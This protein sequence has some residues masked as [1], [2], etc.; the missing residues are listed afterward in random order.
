MKLS[1]FILLSDS[2]KKLV[3]LHEG[4]LIAKRK[5]VSSMIFLFQLGSY[6]VETLCN[7]A[8]KSIEE[9]RAFHGTRPLV[10][11]LEDIAIDDLLN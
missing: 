8:D 10:P 3:V 11:Y 5:Q 2:E 4:V 1:D 9:Y 6:Y 7:P